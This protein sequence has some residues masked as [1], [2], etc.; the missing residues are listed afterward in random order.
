[1]SIAIDQAFTNAMIT[2]GLA[3][4]LVHENGVYSTWNGSSYDS[5]TGVYEPQARR[6]FAEMRHFPADGAPI[7]LA[8]TNENTGLYQVLLKY[9]AVVADMT[10]KLKAEDVLA[11]LKPTALLTYAGQ[12]VEIISSSRD[13]GVNAGGYYEIL[14]RANYRAFVAR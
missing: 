7:S 5:Q 3:I 6:E 13:G 2:G 1:M 11:I 9:P 4:D 14:I 12:V 10:A 8:N